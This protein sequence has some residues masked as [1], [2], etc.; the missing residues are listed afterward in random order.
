MMLPHI[1]ITKWQ[2]KN[3][4]LIWFKAKMGMNN[5]CHDINVLDNQQ[6][7]QKTSKAT[8]DR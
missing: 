5:K 7:Q 4:K 8:V 2:H 6:Q 3:K 1:E